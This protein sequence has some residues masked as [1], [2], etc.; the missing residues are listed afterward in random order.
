VE[1]QH[2]VLKLLLD[3]CNDCILPN[4]SRGWMVAANSPY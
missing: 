1:V 3:G 4:D 2:G